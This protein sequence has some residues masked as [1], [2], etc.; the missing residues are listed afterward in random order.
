MLASVFVVTGQDQLRHPGGRVDGARPLVRAADK[1][2]GT[3][4]NPELAVRVNGALMTGAGALLALG[5]FPRMSSAMLAAGLV[6]TTLA[7]HAFWNETDPE[8]KRQQRSKF[9]TNVAL[10][11]GLLIAA[12]DTEGKPGLAWRARQAKIEASK[13]AD[14][15]QRQA[16]RSV[17]QVRKDAGRE[18][19]L[20]RLKASNTVS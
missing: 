1:A 15:A 17:E 3:H 20:L 7:E 11:G 8:T 14:R 9:L 12:A 5:K 2:A 18:A 16:A 4:T 6:P 19:Q 10:M 13:A